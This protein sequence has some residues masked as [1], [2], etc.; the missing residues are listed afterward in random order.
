M[1]HVI[2]D[3]A[4]MKHAPHKPIDQAGEQG[5]MHRHGNCIAQNIL[6]TAPLGGALAG[7]GIQL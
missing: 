1:A 3:S 6:V 4:W 7:S 2:H 5:L